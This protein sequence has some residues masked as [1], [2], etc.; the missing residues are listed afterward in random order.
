MAGIEVEKI[1]AKL[2]IE[3][4][5]KKSKNVLYTLKRI[6]SALGHIK[7]SVNVTNK[8]LGRTVSQLDKVTK[9]AN[10]AAKATSKLGKAGA[11]GGRSKATGRGRGGGRSIRRS[12]A[13]GRERGGGG[14]TRRLGGKLGRGAARGGSAA[15]SGGMVVAGALV[16]GA[17][18]VGGAAVSGITSATKAAIEFESKMAD[19]RKVVGGLDDA[20]QFAAM[21]KQIRDLSKIVPIT[22]DG[23]A[24][25]VA[26]AG[27]AGIAKDKLIPFA[28]QAAKVGV[29]FD[30]SADKA[31]SALAKVKTSLRLTVPETSSLMGTINELSNSMASSAPEILTVVK[32]VAALGQQA[33][34][35]GQQT[36]ALGS[37][38]IAAGAN[39]SIARTAT[40]NLFLAVGQGEAA[41]DKT[42]KALKK[43]GLSA[44]DLALDM[45]EDAEG[46]IRDVFSRIQN[47]SAEQRTPVITQIFGKVSSGAIGPLIS[48][49]DLLDKAFKKANDTAAAGTSVQ[50]EFDS[51][52][53]TTANAIQLLKNRFN[54]AKITIG[55]KF[56]PLFKKLLGFMSSP[57]FSK[58][59][60]KITDGIVHL[61]DVG[62]NS[63]QDVSFSFDD[64]VGFVKGLGG[65]FSS[66]Q[67]L[68]KPLISGVRGG[69]GEA[70]QTV[71]TIFE[72]VGD[73][74]DSVRDSF[75]LFSDKEGPSFSTTVK[76]MFLTPLREVRDLF[77]VVKVV[78]KDVF[79][80]FRSFKAGNIGEGLKGI[81][82]ILLKAV[83]EPLRLVTRALINFTKNIP[84][85]AHFIPDSMVNFANGG[86]LAEARRSDAEK[87]KGKKVNDFLVKVGRTL[88][89]HITEANLRNSIELEKQ[90]GILDP[91]AS[92][93]DSPL[94]STGVDGS[95]M[96]EPGGTFEEGTFE[97]VTDSKKRKVLRSK[98]RR[99]RRGSSGSAGRRASKKNK[100]GLLNPELLSGPKSGMGVG[101]GQKPPVLINLIQVMPGAIR[102]GIHISGNFNGT[103]AQNGNAMMR[104]VIDEVSQ[105][106]QLR[107]TPQVS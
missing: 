41:T 76:E 29:A 50:R 65:A 104:L 87:A 49:L 53:A 47:L 63:L 20:K 6:D 74:F 5:K 103:P 36:A 38:M 59:L 107:A 80:V 90:V 45:Q 55:E 67:K 93:L 66:L 51:R 46:T 7:R 75:A 57:S 69:V 37:A 1:V 82:K 99:R 33:G 70:F 42:R 19:V 9:A 88:S 30:I 64:L 43:L 96:S 10:K 95:L 100:K 101:A 35:T 39:A 85:M 83:L 13:T 92:R 16:T 31:G 17:L 11:R 8:N 81:G 102:G 60:D 91:L 2:S 22:A 73:I 25:I 23:I 86:A 24:D 58:A 78:A 14:R 54:S 94:M 56:L 84:G 62:T 48:N 97:E 44:E 32:G 27:Q 98:K 26:A 89:P 105:A 72:D 18:A 28:E 34:L 40:K 61:V 3:I 68:F 12:K 79:D 71:A 4:D 106:A 21:G 15:L 77:K 52:S